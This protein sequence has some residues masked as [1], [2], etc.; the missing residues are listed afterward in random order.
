VANGGTACERVVATE[1]DPDRLN[2]LFRIGVDEISWRYAGENVKRQS[3]KSPTS[4]SGR[5]SIQPIEQAVEDLLASDLALRRSV[6]TLA[7]QR[8]FELYGGNEEGAG[9]TDGRSVPVVGARSPVMMTGVLLTHTR[10]L[11]TPPCQAR[12]CHC[13]NARRSASR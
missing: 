13:P 6:I 11:E 10:P 1:L 8:R 9:F 4:S 3:I 7:Q 12:R 2:G 5:F